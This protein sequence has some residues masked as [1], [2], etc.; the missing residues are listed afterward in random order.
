MGETPL[1][2]KGGVRWMVGVFRVGGTISEDGEE[3]VKSLKVDS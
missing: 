2:T 1:A 3:T